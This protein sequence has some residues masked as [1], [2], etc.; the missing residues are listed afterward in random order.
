[1]PGAVEDW[2]TKHLFYH[3]RA[4]MPVLDYNKQSNCMNLDFKEPELL[5]S[6]EKL[7]ILESYH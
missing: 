3:I 6:L 5:Y 7:L 2:I 1:M 4:L